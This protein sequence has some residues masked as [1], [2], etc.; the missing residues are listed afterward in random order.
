MMRLSTDRLDSFTFKSRRTREDRRLKFYFYVNDIL[1]DRTETCCEYS[2]PVHTRS[3]L[4]RLES[5]RRSERCS[6]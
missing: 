2:F 5:I 1:V 3:D 4:F 6:K